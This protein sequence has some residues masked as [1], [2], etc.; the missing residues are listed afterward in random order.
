MP[1]HRCERAVIVD[2]LPLIRYVCPEI[3][4]LLGIGNKILIKFWDVLHD[5]IEIIPNE[6]I[7]KQDTRIMAVIAVKRLD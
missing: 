4:M 1:E 7:E 6:L 2:V 5:R 3:H